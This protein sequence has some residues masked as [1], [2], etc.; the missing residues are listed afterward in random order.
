LLGGPDVIVVFSG[1]GRRVKR[2]DGA[3]GDRRRWAALDAVVI[4]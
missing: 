1:E 3:R 4:G 2:R